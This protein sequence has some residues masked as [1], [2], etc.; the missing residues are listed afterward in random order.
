MAAL[1][2]Q[3]PAARLGRLRSSRTLA[4]TPPV[5]TAAWRA[6]Y[7]LDRCRDIPRTVQL[8]L[9][10]EPG[11][12][13]GVDAAYGRAATRRSGVAET[14]VLAVGNAPS[15]ASASSARLQRA[16]PLPTCVRAMHVPVVLN[17]AA[18]AFRGGQVQ[19]FPAGGIGGSARSGRR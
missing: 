18:A 13:V 4:G 11:H 5:G 3:S 6:R 2:S 1:V 7:G 16:S 10:N 9:P 8:A 19:W 14:R 17:A 12:A 15:E